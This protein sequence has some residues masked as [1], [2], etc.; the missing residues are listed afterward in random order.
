MGRCICD[1]RHLNRRFKSEKSVVTGKSQNAKNA[2]GLINDVVEFVAYLLDWMVVPFIYW[3]F[4]WTQ[5]MSGWIQ[6]VE[7]LKLQGS[8]M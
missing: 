3:H 8:L 4:V 5:A 1:I 2:S 6:Q 7:D